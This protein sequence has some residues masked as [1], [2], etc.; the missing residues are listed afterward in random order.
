[1]IYKV[2]S[3]GNDVV[4]IQQA[5]NKKLNLS[6]KEDGIFGTGTRDAVKKFQTSVQLKSDGV[7]GPMTWDAL[8]LNQ[9]PTPTSSTARVLDSENTLITAFVGYD[10]SGYS[11]IGATATKSYANNPKT[12]KVDS[13]SITTDNEEKLKSFTS[14]IFHDVAK[15][16]ADYD[17]K[18]LNQEDVFYT[19]TDF[20]FVYPQNI[21][22][23][24]SNL[25][26]LEKEK[27]REE[28]KAEN[29]EKLQTLS[30]NKVDI[31]TITGATPEELKAQG[32]SRLQEI[33]F[34]LGKQIPVLILPPLLDIIREYIDG[35]AEDACPTPVE[36]ERIIELRNKLVDQLN[37]IAKQIDRV[38]TALTGV[39]TFLNIV[40]STINSVDIASVVLSLASKF[41]PSPPGVPG[42]AVSALNDA[43]TFIRK[44]TFN[45]KGESK[46]AKTNAA[47]NTASLS[48]AMV[49]S[50][51]LLAIKYITLI[52][53]LINFCKKYPTLTPI[54][55]EVILI[56][57]IQAKAEE[58]LN[59]STY[60]G[61]LIEIETIPYTPTVNRSRAVGKNQYGIIMISTELS[62]TSDPTVLINELKYIIDRDNLKAY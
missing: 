52:D 27:E 6:L 19:I 47:I 18:V 5:L 25:N 57:Q 28:L 45:E 12:F 16:I 51:I 62:F 42:F 22:I 33:I 53:K 23:P 61:F 36:L 14:Q 43:Q 50:Y 1:M 8:G 40:I 29:E 32:I 26:S 48:L 15:Q 58:T 49:S 7:V 4:K 60:Q 31:E 54:S 9:T 30:I 10:S 17:S 41:I 13:L 38:G 39:A 35:K 20:V 21:K 37:N 34:N 55:P 56:S 2:G 11:T 44:A 24:P 59:Q 3:K 46:L